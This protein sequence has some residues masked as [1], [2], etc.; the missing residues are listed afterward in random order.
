MTFYTYTRDK[1]G[2]ITSHSKSIDGVT[3]VVD[4]NYDLA[5]RLAKIFGHTTK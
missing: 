1:L 2:R 3:V 5:G 4:Y